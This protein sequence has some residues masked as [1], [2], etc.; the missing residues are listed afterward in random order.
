MVISSPCTIHFYS[1]LQFSRFPSLRNII[2][3]RVS[4]VLAGWTSGL[5][6]GS[7]PLNPL[8]G[9]LAQFHTHPPGLMSVAAWCVCVRACV[10]CVR[11]CVCVLQSPYLSHTNHLNQILRHFVLYTHTTT[12]SCRFQGPHL[13]KQAQ[14]KLEMCAQELVRKIGIYEM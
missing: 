3:T 13:P 6:T 2:Q 12:L 4:P 1:S 5:S 11:V 10:A 7:S 14:N 9:V 8:M